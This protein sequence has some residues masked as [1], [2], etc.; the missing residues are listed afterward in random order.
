MCASLLPRVVEV[1]NCNCI[2]MTTETKER[3]RDR[4]REKECLGNVDDILKCEIQQYNRSVCVCVSCPLQFSPIIIN[5]KLK[6]D[7]KY[8]SQHTVAM[9]GNCER[10]HNFDALV[11]S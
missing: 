10:Y 3:K 11:Y 1:H 6:T 2:E 7:K 9:A 8:D 4:Q 5:A